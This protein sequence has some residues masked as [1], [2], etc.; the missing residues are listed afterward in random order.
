MTLTVHYVQYMGFADEM[1]ED[2]LSNCLV[3]L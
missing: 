3:D 2:N 1:Y